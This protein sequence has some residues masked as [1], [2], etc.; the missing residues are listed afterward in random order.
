MLTNFAG[1]KVSKNVKKVKKI[2]F[3]PSSWDPLLFVYLSPSLRLCVCTTVTVTDMPLC[4]PLFFL[5]A[6]PSHGFKDHGI[7]GSSWV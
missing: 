6:T 1:K 4:L 2:I 3:I 7:N 5:D